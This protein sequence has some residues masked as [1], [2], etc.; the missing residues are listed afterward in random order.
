MTARSC[1]RCGAL[2]CAIALSAVPATA[3]SA[4]QDDGIVLTKSSPKRNEGPGRASHARS[5]SRAKLRAVTGLA[6]QAG[7][8]HYFVI[9]GPEG[10]PE[11]QVGIE[12]ADGRIV[13]SFPEAGVFVGPFMAWGSFT[14]GSRR[15]DVEHLFGLRPF[16]DD[17][18][19]RALQ[20]ALAS[21]VAPFLDPWTPYCAETGSADRYCLSCLG[22]VLRVLFPGKTRAYPALPV[23]FRSARKDVYSTEDLLLYLAGV[24]IDSSRIARARRIQAL[25]VPAP[26]REELS[27]IAAGLDDAQSN[28]TRAKNRVHGPQT[29]AAA[30]PLDGA[31]RSHARRS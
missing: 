25:D 3:L 5:D 11:T 9:T 12:L 8:V 29:R 30:Q 1:T 23:D 4:S 28:G 19:M 21:R 6:G 18:S 13:W 15:Y 31:R 16:H 26:L 2:I 27:R 14:I 10:E 24:P 7:Y 20:R 22:F 17:G